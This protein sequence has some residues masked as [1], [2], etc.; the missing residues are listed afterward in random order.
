MCIAVPSFQPPYSADVCERITVNV[1]NE[2]LTVNTKITSRHTAQ[3]PD[4]KLTSLR[5]RIGI[6]MQIALLTLAGG[7]A[8]NSHAAEA[9]PP[10]L[11]EVWTCSYNAGKDINDLMAARD[12]YVKQAAK[13]GLSLGPVYLW[14]LIKGDVDFD[15]IWLEP[16]ESP[17]AYAAAMDAETAAEEMADVQ[18]R[19]DAVGTCRAL[20]GQLHNAFA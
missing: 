14:S 15:I 20:T 3:L 8:V 19:F 9:Q 17:M 6:L 18:A 13:A 11:V 16:H 10:G 5:T 1:D 12:Y 2:E 4:M 7:F